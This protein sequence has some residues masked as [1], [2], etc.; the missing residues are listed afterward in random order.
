MNPLAIIL[1]IGLLNLAALSLLMKH[2]RNVRNHRDRMPVIGS[3]PKLT[4]ALHQRLCA[5][6]PLSDWLN[7]YNLRAKCRRW[8]R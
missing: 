7:P 8:L 2:R 4:K 6:Q 1:L 3:D 5:N